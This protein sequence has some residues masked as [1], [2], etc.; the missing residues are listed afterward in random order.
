M[1]KEDYGRPWP[2]YFLNERFLCLFIELDLI[3]PIPWLVPLLFL[4]RATFSS[5]DT[6]AIGNTPY[7][8]VALTVTPG[9]PI[10][11]LS[12]GPAVLEP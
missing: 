12:S 11:Y 9:L 7:C 5:F 8:N 3:L 1:L 2:L 4:I 6:F 10:L